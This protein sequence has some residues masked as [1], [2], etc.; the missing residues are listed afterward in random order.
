MYSL[1]LSTRTH[2]PSIELV[3]YNSVSANLPKPLRH[4]KQ[5]RHPWRATTWASRPIGDFPSD[6]IGN[7]DK[8][9]QASKSDAY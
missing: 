3:L 5:P 7:A 9:S 4:T 2:D 1:C 6:R 8:Q